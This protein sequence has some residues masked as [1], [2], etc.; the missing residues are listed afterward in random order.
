MIKQKNL[1][2]I[3]LTTLFW[4]GYV[5]MDSQL[6]TKMFDADG[7]WVS[8]WQL[9]AP[10]SQKNFFIFTSYLVN[11]YLGLGYCGLAWLFGKS[12]IQAIKYIT[13]VTFSSF[14][15]TFLKLLY[16]YPRPFMV[17]Q[18]VQALQCGEDFGRPSGH[19][20][21]GFTTYF[22]LFY[23]YI[24]IWLDSIYPGVIISSNQTHRAI[25]QNEFN[26]SKENEQDQEISNRFFKLSYV[27]WLVCMG[28]IL[29][30]GFGRMYLGVHSFDQVLLGWVYA[31]SY[32]MF[33]IFFFDEHYENFL[34]YLI[35][36]GWTNPIKPIIMVVIPFLIIIITPIIAYE[37]QKPRIIYDPIW[38]SNLLVKC[39]FD[40]SM[41]PY[42]LLLPLNFTKCTISMLNFG[43]LFGILITKGE[44]IESSKYIFLPWHKEILRI[45]VYL[46]CIVLPFFTL[47]TISQNTNPYLTYFIRNGLMYFL[48]TFFVVVM[49]PYAFLLMKIDKDGDL[50]RKK[51]KIE[52]A[53]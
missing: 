22:F 11:P 5:I 13:Y 8:S 37:I 50:L 34:K 7:T 45:I 15:E 44:Y 18:N 6:I 16:A 25:D 52:I 3:I 17:F 29:G 42:I 46:A 23:M 41:T 38:I 33:V 19:A 51:R 21:N 30:I 10:K 36:K 28:I 24:N 40:N 26:E 9:S 49:P 12:K 32:S 53:V 35:M 4:I 20:L 48:I 2:I 27:G 39:G 31:F 1:L 14:T 43:I 47:N